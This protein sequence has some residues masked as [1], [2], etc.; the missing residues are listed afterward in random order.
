MCHGQGAASEEWGECWKTEIKRLRDQEVCY[1]EGCFYSCHE[2]TLE[3]L[4]KFEQTD[5]SNEKRIHI[6]SLLQHMLTEKAS[7]HL[8]KSSRWLK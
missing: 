5:L 4:N 6:L 1:T 3:Q 8:T 7:E 2:K